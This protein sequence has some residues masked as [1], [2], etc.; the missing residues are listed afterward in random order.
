MKRST[1]DV[2]GTASVCARVSACVS[3]CVCVRVIACSSSCVTDICSQ[4]QLCVG[5]KKSTSSSRS[6]S[7]SSTASKQAILNREKVVQQCVKSACFALLVRLY[8][9]C[10][11]GVEKNSEAFVA[12]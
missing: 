11:P 7:S 8:S 1:Q 12:A 3:A 6:S 5:R 9:V 10:A 2:S 4:C